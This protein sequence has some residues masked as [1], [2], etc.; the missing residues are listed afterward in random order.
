MASFRSDYEDFVRNLAKQFTQHLSSRVDTYMA[1]TIQAFDAPWPL[2]QANAIYFACSLLSL[3]DDQHI[4]TV[5][6]TQVFS[7]L[8]GKM[9][10]SSHAVVR[11]T[12][13]SALGLLLKSTNSR[14]WR[15]VRL[16]RVDS[17]RK[18]QGSESPR[19]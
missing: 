17:I 3:S 18:G 13:F 15:E 7:L 14:S 19:K 8:V 16:D 6:Y 5:Y 4:L 1:S 11:A 10:R 12:C 2:I 9:S